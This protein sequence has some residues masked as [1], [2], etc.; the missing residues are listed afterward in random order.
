M[1]SIADFF[2]LKE[3]KTDVGTEVRA[4]IATFLT[5]AYIIVVNPGILS[6]TGMPF[7]GVLFATVLVASLSS[8]LMGLVTN[9]PFAIAPGMGLNAFFAFSLCIGMKIP[10]QTALGVVFVSGVIFLILSITGVRQAIVQSIPASLRYG[11]AAGIGL[12]L[13]I[14][15]LTSVKFIVTSPATTVTFGG[16][17]PTT[18]LFLI[19]LAITGI[20]IARKVKGS[21][22]IGIAATSLLALIASKTIDGA[23]GMITVPD[24]IFAVP[25]LDV[26][27]QL[28]ILGALTV[29][30]AAPIFT[31]LFTDIFDSLSTFLGVS[32][33]GGFIEKDGQPKNV[34]KALLVD[35]VSTTISGLF[36]TSSG[37]TYI[38]SASG[39]EEGGRTGLTAVVTG[40][41]FLPF[42]FLS[43]LLSFVP[44][45]ATAPILVLIGLFMMK[46]VAKIAWDDY[47]EAI[48]AFLALI[49]IPLTYSITQGIVWGF[50]SYTVLKILKGKIRELPLMIYIIDAGAILSL[51]YH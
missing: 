31:F 12:F 50:L 36:G 6:N 43:P 28:D 47:E 49:L 9:L 33:V 4:G 5:M 25:S 3:N 19:G 42:M 8:I 2:K 44:A 34:G 48:P 37:T 40:L 17:N 24:S 11:V 38:E 41:L 14:I 27:F 20:L 1:S 45:V 13:S 18:I 51:I 22:I 29:S 21:L 46:P 23:A 35:A 39:I 7:A 15:G 30:M 32:E 26:F 16:I 10:W